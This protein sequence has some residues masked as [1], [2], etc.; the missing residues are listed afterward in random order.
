M[1]LNTVP[2]RGLGC[3][4]RLVGGLQECLD[5]C[6]GRAVVGRHA[7]A[8]GDTQLLFVVAPNARGV[9]N[10]HTQT[11]GDPLCRV[12]TRVGEDGCELLT[13]V[14]EHLATITGLD[15]VRF[16][17]GDKDAVAEGVPIDVV[18]LLKV[19]YVTKEDADRAIL[20][21]PSEL[22]I[23]LI[24]SSPIR[25]LGQCVGADLGDQL[26]VLLLR[27]QRDL[28]QRL[29]CL[30]EDLVRVPEVPG[31]QIEQVAEALGLFRMSLSVGSA[32]SRTRPNQ[33]SACS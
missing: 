15:P 10:R 22:L 6:E 12:V 28:H 29:V 30:S 17:N 25:N 2:A 24:E 27:L 33:D 13:T 19:I 23:V 11:L 5:V 7:D 8:E 20:S 26:R 14:A 9:G 4:Q 18:E 3:V 31:R 21:C 1:R 32:R 16:R